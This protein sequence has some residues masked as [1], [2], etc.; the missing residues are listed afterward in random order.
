MPIDYSGPSEDV[1]RYTTALESLAKFYTDKAPNIFVKDG[2]TKFT[3]LKPKYPF[4]AASEKV[5][6]YVPTLEDEEL[7][8]EVKNEL[9][10]AKF[11]TQN[12]EFLDRSTLERNQDSG[13]MCAELLSEHSSIIEARHQVSEV[14]VKLAEPLQEVIKKFVTPQ[15]HIHLLNSNSKDTSKKEDASTAIVKSYQAFADSRKKFA[16]LYDNFESLSGELER[17]AGGSSPI[18]FL[19]ATAYSKVQK[20]IFAGIDEQ[21]ELWTRF[22][23]RLNNLDVLEAPKIESEKSPKNQSEH[24][25]T[26]FA[27]KLKMLNEHLAVAKE[28]WEEYTE[29]SLKS[30]H[31]EVLKKRGALDD[32]ICEYDI[33]LKD[34]QKRFLQKDITEIVNLVTAKIENLRQDRE[35]E[36]IERQENLKA[37]GTIK[38]IDLK[39]PENYLDW[40]ENQTKLNTHADIYKRAAVLLSTLKDPEIKRRTNGL[41]DFTEIMGIIND[42]YARESTLIPALLNTLRVLPPARTEAEVVRTIGDIRNVFSKVTRLGE[43]AMSHLN[44]TLIEDILRKF[45]MYLQEKWEEYCL[46]HKDDIGVGD[47]TSTV[48]GYIDMYDVLRDTTPLQ[49][50]E[51]AK[52]QRGMFLRFLK[53]YE[54]I[55]LNIETRNPRKKEDGKSTERRDGKQRI[56]AF[57]TSIKQDKVCITCDTKKSHKNKKGFETTSLSSCPS[58]R[59]MKVNDREKV[60]AKNRLCYMCLK[61][62]CNVKV[63]KI[64]GNCF[65]CN[66]RHNVLLCTAPP[67]TK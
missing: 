21:E 9:D 16:I 39:G 42:W 48:L 8:K 56:K 60:V 6:D 13:V 45:P 61:S 26:V 41:T 63:C 35:A 62:G 36:R 19:S 58:F 57:S 20:T 37:L 22:M 67:A 66:K 5:S 54:N 28:S 12:L 49:M 64:Q 38:L 32:M 4:L 15:T 18:P 44:G 40:C 1:P 24:K 53:R 52:R 50:N 46:D 25:K 65:N 27:R 17:K 29:E 3:K 2:A 10:N 14:Y 34:E 30:L 11:V 33:E 43:G 7:I 47:G 55:K 51:D 31:Q 23:M 59:Q